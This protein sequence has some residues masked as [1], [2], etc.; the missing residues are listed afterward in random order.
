MKNV[1]A[2]GNASGFVEPLEATSLGAICQTAQAIAETIKEAGSAPKPSFIRQFNDRNGRSWDAIRKFLAIHYRYNRRID[3]PFWRTCLAEVDLAGAEDLVAYYQENG[4]SL[5]WRDTL[6][7]TFDQF[8]IDGYWTMLVGQ[9]VPYERRVE[10]SDKD[11]TGWQRVKHTWRQQA[12]KGLTVEEAMKVVTSPKW[13]WR[14]DFWK[15][16]RES[17]G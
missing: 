3:T 14:P 6:V 1:V 8:K 16:P 7:D 5:I 15:G 9:S 13:K 11:K 17:G 4:P 2:V 10:I 12:E